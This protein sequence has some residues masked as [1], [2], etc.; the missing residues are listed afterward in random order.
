M[1]SY[2]LIQ[3]PQ[4][5]D[6]LYDV[7]NHDMDLQRDCRYQ[8]KDFA[9]GFLNAMK[10]S[11]E[12]KNLF[13]VFFPVNRNIFLYGKKPK[14][15]G[16]ITRNNSDV[17]EIGLWKEQTATG[18]LDKMQ[19]EDE[20]TYLVVPFFKFITPEQAV[21]SEQEKVLE[22][23]IKQAHTKQSM[24]Y[25]GKLLHDMYKGLSYKRDNGFNPKEGGFN[26]NILKFG[27]YTDVFLALHR[28]DKTQKIR[29]FWVDD[30]FGYKKTFIDKARKF[31][32]GNY[33][34]QGKQREMDAE[35]ETSFAGFVSKLANYD[36]ESKKQFDGFESALKH[37]FVKTEI[38][39][40]KI[41]SDT[42]YDI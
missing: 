4:P 3:K 31:V 27:N 8:L 22:K 37:N 25:F 20:N 19:N 13:E 39:R 5:G 10:F 35:L 38:G 15:F 34:N 17:R 11:A 42:S 33:I 24:V 7:C 29:K 9:N 36:D 40:K 2:V 26:P 16:E 12:S 32:V 14:M 6:F 23:S 30:Y 18:E 41:R 1:V 28:N 21:K